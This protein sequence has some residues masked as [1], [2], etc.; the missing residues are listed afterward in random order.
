MLVVEIDKKG[1]VDRDLDYERK[2]Q[3]EI[4]K[5]NYHLIRINPDKPDFDDY[6]EFGRVSTYIAESIQKQTERS[7]QLKNR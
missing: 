5:L 6:K 1:H 3:K 2:R 7:T 4:E